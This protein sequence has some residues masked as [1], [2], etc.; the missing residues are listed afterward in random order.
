MCPNINGDDRFFGNDQF[1]G[2]SVGKI[3][4]NGVKRLQFSFQGMNPEG[5][6]MGVQFQEFEGFFVL[7]D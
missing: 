2:H 4:G 5:G 1:D 6:M 3:Y 7:A